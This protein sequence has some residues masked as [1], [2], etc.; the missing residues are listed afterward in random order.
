MLNV[1]WFFQ[2]LGQK[3]QDNEFSAKDHFCVSDIVL[4]DLIWILILG[5]WMFICSSFQK[6][7]PWNWWVF[8][9]VEINHKG[10]E[11][12]ADWSLQ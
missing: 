12:F 11:L 10:M 3:F 9:Q 4:I 5:S 7:S 8:G 6:S 1:C 2:L